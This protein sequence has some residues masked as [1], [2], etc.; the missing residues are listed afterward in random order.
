MCIRDRVISVSGSSPNLIAL[1]EVARS[2][3]IVSVGLLGRDGGRAAQIVDV[4]VVVPSGDYGWVEAAHVVLHHIITYELRET[5]FPEE[6]TPGPQ[7]TFS[8]Q[9]VENEPD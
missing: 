8:E 9:V 2:K 7:K 5:A 4:P 3:G 6:A 1:L